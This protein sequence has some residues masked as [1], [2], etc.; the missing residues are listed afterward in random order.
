M[1][2]Y[3]WIV[4]WFILSIGFPIVALYHSLMWNPFLNVAASDGTA[5]ETMGNHVMAPLHYLCVGKRAQLQGDG[6]YAIEQRFDYN[7]HFV[8]NTAA[9]ALTVPIALP[10]GSLLKGAAYL[11]PYVRE[12]H[13]K[14]A[15]TIYTSEI[16]SNLDYYNSI[17]LGFEPDYDKAEFIAPPLHVRRP[18]S[19]NHLFDGKV[20]L[21]AIGEILQKKGIPYWADCGTCL[22]AYRY[23]GVIPWDFDCDIGVLSRDFENIWHALQELNQELYQVQDWSSRYSGAPYLKVY[24]KSTGVLIDIFHYNIDE[25]KKQVYQVIANYDSRFLSDSWRERELTYTTPLAFSDVFPL[26]MAKFD[27]IEIP[28]PQRTKEFL[29]SKY[30]KNIE[31]ARVYSEETASYEKDLSHPYWEKAAN[32]Y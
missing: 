2:H 11:S 31:P 7:D 24:V 13:K 27:D 26:K 10:V 9:A 21:K 30:G 17:S 16:A 5:L 14:I 6:T 1:G 20:A 4:K 32:N 15:H 19:E 3:H 28:V 23:G 12:R 25:E 29:Q 22:G 8:M 18:G